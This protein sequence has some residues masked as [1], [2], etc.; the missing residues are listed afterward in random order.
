MTKFYLWNLGRG[1][2]QFYWRLLRPQ[3]INA[4]VLENIIIENDGLWV[5]TLIKTDI[6]HF[7]AVF[8]PCTNDEDLNLIKTTNFIRILLIY[9]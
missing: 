3:E 9:L 6:N 8:I 2:S 4:I 1:K 7:R 5:N